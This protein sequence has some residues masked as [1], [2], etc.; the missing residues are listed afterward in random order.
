MPQNGVKAAGSQSELK[1]RATTIENWMND[2]ENKEEVKR[3][4]AL[5]G[6]IIYYDITTNVRE[7]NHQ[8]RNRALFMEDFLKSLEN[9]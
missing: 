5:E 3:L 6:D 7:N 9:S 8:T 2:D 4:K 1:R